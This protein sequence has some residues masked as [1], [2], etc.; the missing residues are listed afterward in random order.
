M[1]VKRPKPYSGVDNYRTRVKPQI[2]LCLGKIII[3]DSR[4][5]IFLGRNSPFGFLLVV[6]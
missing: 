6:F 3:L 5:A 2:G 4:L 1:S